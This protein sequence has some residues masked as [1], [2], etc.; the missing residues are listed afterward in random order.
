MQSRTI[1]ALATRPS[2]NAGS[3]SFYCLSTGHIINRCN[4]TAFP[5]SA[6]VIDQVH[7]HARCD[8]VKRTITFTNINIDNLDDIHA[9]IDCDDDDIDLTPEGD[10]E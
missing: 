9:N 3:Y 2:N 6:E 10:D 8:N 5:I 1:G 4:W 7:M